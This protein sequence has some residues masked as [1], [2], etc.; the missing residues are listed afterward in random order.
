M[1]DQPKAVT[2]ASDLLTEFGSS[3]G[4]GYFAALRRMPDVLKALLNEYSN[5]DEHTDLLI[6]HLR[7]K[8]KGLEGTEGTEADEIVGKTAGEVAQQTEA[9]LTRLESNL[10]D[11]A[12]DL[13]ALNDSVARLWDWVH[14]HT[15][16]HPL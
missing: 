12:D 8:I 6:H 13:G 1:S 5:L 7:N 2:D 3:H 10:G 14:F 16:G 15:A 4:E 9:R 11:L